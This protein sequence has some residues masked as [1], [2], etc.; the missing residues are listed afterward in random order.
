MSEMEDNSWLC[1]FG[2]NERGV[3]HSWNQD[4]EIDG[5]EIGIRKEPTSH[6]RGLGHFTVYGYIGFS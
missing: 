3:R 5:T 2:M 6:I 1:L 4:I